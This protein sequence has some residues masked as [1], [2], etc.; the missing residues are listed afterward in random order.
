MASDAERVAA[1]HAASWRR[2]YRGAYSDAYLDG[3]VVADRRGVW[4]PRLASAAAAGPAPGPAPGPPPAS[5]TILAEEA[6]ELVGFVHVVFDHDERW[7]SLV[8][9]LHVAGGRQRGGLGTVL[10]ARAARAAAAHAKSASVYLWVLEQNDSARSFY[11]AR[12]G[13]HVETATVDPPGGR[14]ERL[15]GTPTKLRIVWADVAMLASFAVE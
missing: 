5:S 8:D 7:G 9:N 1:L 12:G 14:A 3:D 13:E 2:H 15:N 10:L 11:A 4:V 6:G